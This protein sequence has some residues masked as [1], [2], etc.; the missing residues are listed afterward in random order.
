MMLNAG[1]VKLAEQ[2]RQIQILEARLDKLEQEL[3]W[4]PRNPPPLP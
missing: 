3:P 1:E 4:D 2:N